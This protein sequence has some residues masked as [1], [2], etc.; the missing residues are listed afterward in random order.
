MT[1][2]AEDRKADLVNRLA[3][4]ARARAAS[5]KADVAEQFVRRYFALVAPEDIIYTSFDTLLGG[6]LSL[7]QFGEQRQAGKPKIRL[8]NPTVEANGWALEHT[9]IE[10]VNDDMPFLVDSVSA[11]LNRLDRTIHLLLHPVAGAVSYMHVEIDQE[12]VP[13][14]LERIGA[15]IATVLDDVRVAVAD[16]KAMR[17]QLTK[18]VAILHDA[19]LPMP[20]EEV[21]EAREF[22]KWLDDG[23]RKSTR[24]NSSH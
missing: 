3:T 1:L 4:E 17:Q 18:E 11:E 13:A 14:E 24:L 16:F 2:T 6:A 5:D 7:W 8:F 20:E 19:K 10:I 22:L 12:T 23:D 21:S 9:V 15:S